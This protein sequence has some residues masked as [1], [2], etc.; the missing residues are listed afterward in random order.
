MDRKLS[1]IVA[2]LANYVPARERDLFVESRGQQVISSAVNV[3]TLIEEHYD[4]ETA[5]E[6]TRRLLNAI[7]SGDEQ[8]FR[9]KIKQLRESR[10]K[11]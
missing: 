11:P 9:R 1:G 6:L 2:E 5:G 10:K 4:A 8:K 7:K 3:M